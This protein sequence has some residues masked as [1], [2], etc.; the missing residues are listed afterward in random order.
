MLLRVLI[1]CLCLASG[2]ATAR[3]LTLAAEDDYY[4]FSAEVDGELVG[5]IPELVRAAFRSRDMEVEFRTMPYARVLML[6]RNGTMAGGFTGAID[7]SNA[8]T[9]H[10]HD[11]PLGVVRLA[12]WGRKSDSASGLTAADME[13][14]T[15]AVTRGFFYTD[16]IDHNDRVQKA[17]APS[18]ES[19]LK[20]LALDRV[21]FALVTE[22]I[23]HS[24]L[25]SATSPQ[26]Q[27][28]VEVV[29]QIARVPLHAFFSRAHPRGEE[30]AEQF[31]RGL[32]AIRASGEFD[33]IHRR[34]LPPGYEP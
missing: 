11:T 31:Q 14:R 18:D 24:I 16:A 32:E 19:S 15:V 4:P 2:T 6:V 9:F 7:D 23:G 13:G 17:V 12:I 26:L 20:M 27:G 8:S 33:R 28:K 10:W 5:L 34:W 25:E 3:T 1:V 21:D 30:A 29:G 22:R